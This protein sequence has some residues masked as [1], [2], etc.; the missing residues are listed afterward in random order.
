MNEQT[1]IR[2]GIIAARFGKRS[3]APVDSAQVW[4]AEYEALRAGVLRTAM[5]EIAEVLA[6]D[7]HRCEVVLDGDPEARSIDLVVAP[8]GAAEKERRIRFFARDDP[9]RGWQVVGHIWLLQSPSELTRFGHPSEVTTE[10]AEQILVDAIEQLFASAA[11]SA[12]RG[13][14]HS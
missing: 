14:A 9:R 11:S 3:D 6:G 10:V 4:L 8:W 7:G 12:R 5:S 1:R 13:E 2:L